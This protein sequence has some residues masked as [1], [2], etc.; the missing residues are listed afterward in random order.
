M[1]KMDTAQQVDTQQDTFRYRGVK[2]RYRDPGIPS[3]RGNPLIEPLPPI[4]NEED[5]GRLLKFDPGYD[6]AYRQWE[7]ELRLHLILDAMRFLQPMSNHIGL[8]QLISG[9]IRSGYVG[10]NPFTTKGFHFRNSQ[11][12]RLL[13]QGLKVPP[14]LLVTARGC[15]IVGLSGVGKTTAINAILSLYDQVI[16]HGRYRGRL[17]TLRQLV[18]LKLECPQDGLLS[19]LCKSFFKEVDRLLETN[20]YQLY[21]R[22]GRRSID[23]M[24]IDMAGVA[25]RHCLGVLVIDEIQNLRDAKGEGAAHLLNFLLHLN[26]QLEIPVILVGT[27]KALPVLSG[28]FRMARRSSGLGAFPW[29]RMQ[30]DEEWNVFTKALWKYQYVKTDT[31]LSN[32]LRHVLYDESQGITDLAVKLYMLAQIEAI[33]NGTEAVTKDILE[34]VARHRFR[35]LQRFLDALRTPNPKALE[36]YEDITPVD[37]E[38]VVQEAL[39]KSGKSGAGGSKGT[40]AEGGGSTQQEE[41]AAGSADQVQKDSD[42]KPRSRSSGASRKK[43]D[44]TESK[45]ELVR[46]AASGERVGVTAYESLKAA[47]HIRPATEY[48]IEGGLDGKVAEV[49]C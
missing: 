19:G 32:E 4:Y 29:D 46:I 23:D 31:P 21:V 40:S 48:L 6:E 11:R 18:W 27:P 49:T 9:M 35:Y 3:Y 44:A 16:N 38:A 24:L 39:A 13:K 36:K 12:L 28:E 26:N 37:L 1:Y 25:A 7:P 8:E 47:G 22:S 20:T 15:A 41:K 42:T 5:V 10:R 45:L 34:F 14:P 2:A 17:F 33:T 43:E 30:E